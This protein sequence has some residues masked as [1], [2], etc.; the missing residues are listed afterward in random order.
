MSLVFIPP[1]ELRIRKNADK[2]NQD[3]VVKS[4]EGFNKKEK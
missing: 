1:L 2:I 3:K 4:E